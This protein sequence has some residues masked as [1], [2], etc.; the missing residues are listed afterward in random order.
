LYSQVVLLSYLLLEEFLISDS[1]VVGYEIDIAI[2]V[3]CDENVIRDA[4]QN[5]I[6][7]SPARYKDN[8]V[9]AINVHNEIV[10]AL[11]KIEEV[12][13]NIEIDETVALNRIVDIARSVL[14]AAEV[15][16][17]E[18]YLTNLSVYCPC[19]GNERVMFV[20]IPLYAGSEISCPVC[21]TVFR[22]ELSQLNADVVDNG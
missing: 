9:T 12:Y 22:I 8:I 6:V 18:K 14:K 10:S 13:L 1:S 11:Q 17:Y 15:V 20:D 19:C 5:Q 4:R 16:G 7:L 21:T 3:Y 2:P